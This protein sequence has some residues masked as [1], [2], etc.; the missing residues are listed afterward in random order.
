MTRN[1]NRG[2]L[3]NL[4]DALGGVK[5]LASVLGVSR[6]VIQTWQNKEPTVTDKLR[7]NIL[8]RAMKLEEIY[9]E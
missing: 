7:V 9:K 3:D 6:I 2:P 4:I 5:Q 1:R 8:C